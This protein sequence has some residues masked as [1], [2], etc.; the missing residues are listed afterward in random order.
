M[1]IGLLKWDKGDKEGIKGTLPFCL[2]PKL[3]LGNA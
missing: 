1:E 3:L 2:V